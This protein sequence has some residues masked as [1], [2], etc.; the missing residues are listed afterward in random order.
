MKILIAHPAALTLS[1][2]LLEH[3]ARRDRRQELE[4]IHVHDRY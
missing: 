2:G 4:E 1:A 3:G